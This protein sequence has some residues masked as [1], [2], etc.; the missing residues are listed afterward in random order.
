MFYLGKKNVF[1]QKLHLKCID[2]PGFP[3]QISCFELF[4]LTTTFVGVKKKYW[5]DSSYYW[6]ITPKC[7]YWTSVHP[8][9]LSSV[10]PQGPEGIS[11]L[12]ARGWR[13]NERANRKQQKLQVFRASTVYPALGFCSPSPPLTSPFSSNQPSPFTLFIPSSPPHL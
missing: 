11:A 2:C 10:D 6:V 5:L 13:V 7:V 8:P 9:A 4:F 1:L 3:P 12:I